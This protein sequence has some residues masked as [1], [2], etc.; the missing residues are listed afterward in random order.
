MSA[1]TEEALARLHAKVAQRLTD[2]LDS[3]ESADVATIQA[4]IKFLKDNNIQAAPAAE[5][6][7]LEA[8]LAERRRRRNVTVVD[9]D[10]AR[11]AINE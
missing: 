9:L 6:S 8:K 1:A 10:A 2:A 4:A 5:T 3:D 7:E 11:K